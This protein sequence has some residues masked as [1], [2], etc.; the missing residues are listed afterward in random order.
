MDMGYEFSAIVPGGV[1]WAEPGMLIGY[2]GGR[3]PPDNWKR[4]PKVEREA[5]LRE[6][7][8]DACWNVTPWDSLGDDQISEL[9]EA[10]FGQ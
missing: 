3:W 10:A 9:Y 1:I 4:K 7:L 6:F 2:S 8:L 5:L